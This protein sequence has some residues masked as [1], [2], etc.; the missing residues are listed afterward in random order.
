MQLKQRWIYVVFVLTASCRVRANEYIR[1]AV[2][3]TRR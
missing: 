3:Q 2:W 1:I